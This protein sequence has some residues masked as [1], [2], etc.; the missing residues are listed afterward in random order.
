MVFFFGKTLSS[1]GWGFFLSIDY[2]VEIFIEC[3]LHARHYIS[4]AGCAVAS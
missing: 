2:F 1:K 3:P 4:A